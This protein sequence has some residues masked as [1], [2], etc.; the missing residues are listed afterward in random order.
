MILAMLSLLS[1]H[2]QLKTSLL[3]RHEGWYDRYRYYNNQSIRGDAI[4]IG[5]DTLYR[6]C[7]RCFVRDYKMIHLP[8]GVC[9]VLP[10]QNESDLHLVMFLVTKPE[11]I[12]VRKRLRQ[13][14]LSYTK[15]N[16]NPHTRYV[17]VLGRARLQ[18]IQLQIDREQ[19]T[20]NDIVQQDFKEAYNNL[21]LKTMLGVE[22]TTSYCPRAQFIQKVD[23]DVFVNIPHVLILLPQIEKSMGLFGKCYYYNRPRREWGPT[24]WR[25]SE[26]VYQGTRYPSYC[27]GSSYILNMS[28][29]HEIIRIS[30]NIPFFRFEDVYIGLCL[31]A[32]GGYKVKHHGGWMTSYDFSAKAIYTGINCHR[33]SSVFT[34]HHA[35]S[36]IVL[37]VWQKCFS[38]WNDPIKD[39]YTRKM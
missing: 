8:K 35:D 3:N 24:K 23:E 20:H 6:T 26:S 38:K 11:D 12:K 33:I 16:T 15:N 29:A 5:N 9:D 22:W 14:W 25:V 17:F 7:Q 21:T 2:P 19:L 4:E 18:N 34:S 37:K 31:Q 36:N 27:Q 28:V 30:P 13:T 10:G 39:K 32:I 1:R